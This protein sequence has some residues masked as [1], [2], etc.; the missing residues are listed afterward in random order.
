MHA[1]RPVHRLGGAALLAVAAT[2]GCGDAARE[3]PFPSFQSDV[4]TVQMVSAL[5]GGKNVYI[6][7]TVAVA[8]G[9]PHTLSIYNTTEQPHGFAIEGL[10]VEAILPANEE[11]TIPLPALEGGRIYRIH[12][13]LHVPH[14][15]A[16]LVVLPAG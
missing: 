8:A 10:D 7:S 9:K 11:Y 1:R 6:P 3:V 4:S 5:V 14:R 2:F 15:A 13:Q 12:C 16:T